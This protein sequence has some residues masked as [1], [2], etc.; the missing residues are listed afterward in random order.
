MEVR[1][2]WA[3][4]ALMVAVSFVIS[5]LPA[6]SLAMVVNNRNLPRAMPA[7]FMGA[8]WL[9]LVVFG[10]LEVV[11]GGI[12]FWIYLRRTRPPAEDAQ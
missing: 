4:S 12:S 11:S 8:Y 5:A 6:D 1:W 2:K 7:K 3:V 10:V 9:T